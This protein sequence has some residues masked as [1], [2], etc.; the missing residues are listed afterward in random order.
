MRVQDR[1][2]VV[3]RIRGAVSTYGISR[4]GEVLADGEGICMRGARYMAK[5]WPTWITD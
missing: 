5:W 4:R 2:Q 1:R 3:M